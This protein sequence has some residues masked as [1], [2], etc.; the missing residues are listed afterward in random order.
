MLVRESGNVIDGSAVQLR[1]AD[2]SMLVT[3]PLI[4]TEDK[5]EHPENVYPLIVVIELGN[6]IDP[7]FVHP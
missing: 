6:V 5:A 1:N 3:L 4:V 7:S 2:E